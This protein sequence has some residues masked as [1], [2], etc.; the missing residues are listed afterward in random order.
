VAFKKAG[1][2][3]W[4][5]SHCLG[6]LATDSTSQLDVFGHDSNPLGVDGAQVGVFEETYKVSLGCFLKSHDS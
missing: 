4:D 3:E 2:S 1:L 5:W 6:S